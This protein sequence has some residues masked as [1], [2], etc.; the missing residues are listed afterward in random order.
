MA[1]PTATAML[2]EGVTVNDA[3][4]ELEPSG[5]YRV[6]WMGWWWGGEFR[7]ESDALLC[8]DW[9][10]DQA[11]EDAVAWVAQNEG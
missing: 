4:I 11:D 2:H 8:R 10:L 6:I 5:H 9:C 7:H 3:H 1:V